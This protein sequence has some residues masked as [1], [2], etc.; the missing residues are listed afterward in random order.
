MA[1]VAL[2]STNYAILFVSG[3]ITPWA[4]HIEI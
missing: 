1:F 2:T 3:T 4:V